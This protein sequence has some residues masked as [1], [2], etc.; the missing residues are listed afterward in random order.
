M[1][2]SKFALDLKVWVFAAIIIGLVFG[3][4]NENSSAFITVAL[5][6]QMTF[7]FTAV[8]LKRSYF[9]DYRRQIIICILCTFVANLLITLFIGSFFKDPIGLWY[10]WVVFACTPCAIS[11][12][13]SAFFV[14]ADVKMAAVGVT[15]VYIISLI[16]TPLLLMLILGERI[17]PMEVARYILMF[18][19]IPYLG[20][21]P[22]KKLKIG[23]T[24]RSVGINAMLFVTTF[25]AVG[26]HRDFMFTYPDVIAW[27]VVACFIRLFLFMFIAVH[28]MR[29]ARVPR[30]EGMI[31]MQMSVFKTAG[32]SMTLAI[33]LLGS[34]YPAA[35]VPGIISL[36]VEMVWL[37]FLAAKHE[38]VWPPD[39]EPEAVAS[40]VPDCN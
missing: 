34:V 26:A 17:R 30:E 18:I 21:I 29:R 10:G 40:T 16:L 11:I 25:V 31:Y 2:V 33:I 8:E 28:I 3:F 20:A 14:K 22:L 7:S 12:L 6:I 37:A 38:W 1:D 13:T 32:M 9:R 35:P 27:V 23:P 5:I 19:V 39:K 36:P 15:S 24:T 4:D